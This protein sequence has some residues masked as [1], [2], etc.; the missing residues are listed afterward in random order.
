MRLL[1]PGGQPQP[2]ET[3]SAEQ[4]TFNF[5]IDRGGTFTDVFAEVCG[6]SVLQAMCRAVLPHACAPHLSS[7]K[8]GVFDKRRF[9]RLF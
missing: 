2:S 4:K 3:M 8:S 7:R 1:Q 6:S 9:E 5:S